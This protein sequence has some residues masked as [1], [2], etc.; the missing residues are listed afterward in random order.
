MTSAIDTDQTSVRPSEG[1]AGTN[2]LAIRERKFLVYVSDLLVLLASLYLALGVLPDPVVDQDP[3]FSF[4]SWSALLLFTW[5]VAARVLDLYDLRALTRAKRSILAAYWAVISTTVFY[6]AVPYLSP[7]LLASRLSV[8]VFLGTCL[9]GLGAIRLMYSRLVSEVKYRRRAIIVGGGESAAAV[10]RLL[11]DEAAREYHLLG[12]IAD[13]ASGSLLPVVGTTAD[14]VQVARALNVDEV[15]VAEDEFYDSKLAAA[16]IDLYGS[17]IQVVQMSELYEEITGRI[18][19]A[20]IRN[21]WFAALPQRAGGGRPYEFVKFW[22]DFLAA[23]VAVVVL[24]PLFVAITLAIRIDSVGPVLIRQRRV[25]LLGRP[26]TLLKFRSMRADAE[27]GEPIWAVRGDSRRTRVGKLLRRTRLDELPQLWNVLRGD[28]S[29][30]GPR[31]ER[32]EFVQS[33]QAQIPFYRARLLVRP[34]LT[35][36]AQVRYDYAGSAEESLEKLQYDLYYVKHRSPFLDVVVALK[37]I[38]VVMRL[39]G[40]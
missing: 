28:M 27:L 34:G 3:R 18:P 37:T 4:T 17:G 15:I 31:P 22:V 24:S 39:R 30:V 25:G 13:D 21:H 36:W 29:L 5:T 10:H 38:G 35:G 9:F 33:L 12:A 20:H 11:V 23:A 1:R 16:L 40:L 32:V 19:V 14:V 7:P 2:S 26:F 6:L 8:A